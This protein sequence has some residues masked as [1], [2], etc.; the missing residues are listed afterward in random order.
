M[1]KQVKKRLWK[2]LYKLMSNASF[3]KTI[4]NLRKRSVAKFVSNPWQ[5]ETFAQRATSKSFQ[6]IRQYLVSVSFKN[7]Y[8]VWAKP[9]PV[10][11]AILHFSKKS[12]YKFH[13]EEM[14]PR[15]GSGQLKV[16]Y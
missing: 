9:T 16:A 14:V 11:S 6:I 7:S 1:C 15:Y 13:Y 4:E 10:G 3:G 12:L 5:A 8:V 2:E